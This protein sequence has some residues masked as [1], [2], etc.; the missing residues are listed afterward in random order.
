[1]P[2]RGEGDGKD[3]ERRKGRKGRESG[4]YG[5][6]NP[7]ACGCHPGR[8]AS[9]SQREAGTVGELGEEMVVAPREARSA[10]SL[11]HRRVARQ[12]RLSRTLL[13]HVTRM[14]LWLAP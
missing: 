9:R 5:N 7:L 6:A 1:M 12:T 3:D 13:A 8:S 4:Y 14:S 10:H 2:V 11:S